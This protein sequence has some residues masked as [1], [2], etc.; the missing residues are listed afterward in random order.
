MRP[1]RGMRVIVP[2]FEPLE[3]RQL[4]DGSAPVF[5]TPMTDQFMAVDGGL[6]LGVNGF[7]VDGDALTITAV[8]DN[9]NLEI[10]IPTGNR[11]ATLHFTQSNGV[12]AIGDIVV[13]LFDNRS[14]MATSRFVTLA[15]NAVNLDGTLNPSGI[16]FYTNVAVH[17]VI[18]DFMI[19]TGDTVNGDGTGGS[20][21]GTFNDTFDPV[22]SFSGIGVLAMANS[23]VN[24]N[25]CQFFITTGT[26]PWLDQVHMI[27]GQVVSGW[28]VL[29]TLNTV[30]TDSNNSPD[31]SPYDPPRLASVQVVEDAHDGTV[32]M[33]YT[34]KAGGVSHVTIRLD[35]GN[36][37]ITEQTITVQAMGISDPGL[38][39]VTPGE[40]GGFT[41]S[42]NGYTDGGT[43]DWTVYTTLTGASVAVDD[44][45][46]EV[47]ITSPAGYEGVF[48]VILGLTISGDQRMAT[49]SFFV[50]SQASEDQQVIAGL[51]SSTGATEY[52]SDVVGNL[53]YLACGN[54]GIEVYDATDPAQPLLLGSYNT[55]GE[56]RNIKVVGDYAFVSDTFNGL[57]TLNVS[58]PADITLIS[59]TPVGGSAALGL[60]ARDGL[61]Y[62]A[63]YADGLNVYDISNPAQ[64]A[65]VGNIANL[66]KD[67][68][69]NW[70]RF[71]QA[72][73]VALYGDYAYVTEYIAGAVVVLNVSNP[74]SMK[75]V[76]YF[77]SAGYTW[78]IDVCDNRLYVANV[79]AGLLVYSLS[80]PAKPKLL[81]QMAVSDFAC[82]VSVYNQMAVVGTGQSGFWFID[83]HNPKA[84]TMLYHLAS[85]GAGGQATAMGSTLVLPMSSS[86]AILMDAGDL[87]QRITVESSLTITD[88]AGTAITIKASKALVYAYMTAPEGGDIDHIE[89][90]PL[91]AGASRVK[92][93]TKGAA[94]DTRSTVNAIHVS[95][96]LKS[97]TAKTINL[98]GDFTADGMVKSLALGNLTGGT[99]VLPAAPVGD[100]RSKA[101][102]TFDRLSEA[103]IISDIPIKSLTMTDWIDVDAIRDEVT[104]PWL[105]KL[106][107]KGSKKRVISGDFA[108]DLM[109]N[110]DN[111]ATAKNILGKVAIAG[112][113]GDD[114]QTIIDGSYDAA[115]YESIW[116]INGNVGSVTVKGSAGNVILRAAGSIGRIAVAAAGHAD[117]LAGISDAAERHAA[118]VDEFEN[119]LATIKSFKT[120]GI[121]V[122]KGQAA[123]AFLFLD[124]SLS[125]SKIGTVKFLNADF[126]N[127]GQSFGVFARSTGTGKEI[128]SV[129]CINTLTKERISWRKSPQL[130]PLGDLVVDLLN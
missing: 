46:G 128:R 101:V 76:R 123:P 17:R 85:T 70:V 33:Q 81:G 61:L 13:Q 82:F 53:V 8:S 95:G 80:K 100:T 54:A 27:F 75:Y 79:S 31:Q 115:A 119:M 1:N 42:M 73:D 93:T 125:A 91:S 59:T 65:L 102:L 92:I 34:D 21:L 129:T 18:E 37:N 68:S 2:I 96:A 121:K 72:M 63:S 23:G 16:P 103:S 56:A 40:A 111:A 78:G 4:L 66:F 38:L 120:T 41:A 130:F 25:D 62:V 86:G 127:G 10:T 106:S 114:I 99:I 118:N 60:D 47:S 43:L 30:H 94:K 58:N 44:T 12:T 6:T 109:L 90:V 39:R 71:T 97:L 7:D 112:D 77:F 57:V 88:S 87:I 69:R 15:T 26:A 5:A 122:S 9:P 48:Q 11:Y 19:Q 117:F 116:D 22:L 24:T 74:A 126:D 32:T 50:A 36:G 20:E 3:N 108:A 49:R 105:G 64:I 104:A 107:V 52:S 28:D 29:E 35:D 51:P 83:V 84:M 110:Q 67:S 113:W 124:S 89:I 98:N 55:A 45:T 14:L